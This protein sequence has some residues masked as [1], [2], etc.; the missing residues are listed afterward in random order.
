MLIDKGVTDDNDTIHYINLSYCRQRVVDRGAFV[1]SLRE[2]L[3]H[4]T[5]GL[6]E[7]IEC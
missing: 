1:N 4:N 3:D 2:R 6:D 7:S 5:S